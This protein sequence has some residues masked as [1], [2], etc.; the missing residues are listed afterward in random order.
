MYDPHL[1][2]A[3]PSLSPEECHEAVARRAHEKWVKRGCPTGTALA[4]WLEA[5]AELTAGMRKNGNEQ[6]PHVETTWRQVP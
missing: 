4:D 3:C 6:W 1:C 5:E 2:D